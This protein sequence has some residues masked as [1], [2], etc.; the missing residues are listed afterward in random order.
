MLSI[1]LACAVVSTVA[2]FGQAAGAA[3]KASKLQVVPGG[4]RQINTVQGF[5]SDSAKIAKSSPGLF[6]LSGTKLTPVVVKLDYDAIGS[7]RGYLKGYS[8]TSPG[9]THKSLKSN[10]AA[11]DKYSKY[12]GKMDDK[13]RT[14]VAKLIPQAKVTQSLKLAYGGFSALVPANQIPRLL[15]VP[16]VVAVQRDKLNK[17]QTVEEPWQYINADTVWPSL[18][19][20]PNA[21]SNITVADLDTG[22]WPENPMLADNGTIPA[23]VCAIEV[24]KATPTSREAC[25]SNKKGRSL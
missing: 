24:W 15:K 6:R 12:I 8:A 3:P 21:G 13:A 11:V 4:I 10:K 20:L 14:A 2:M 25:G 19:G 17:L 18:G 16:G 23:P 1:M 9:V 22:I 7:Y 5:K